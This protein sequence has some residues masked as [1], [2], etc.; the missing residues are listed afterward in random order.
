M[1]KALI[2][3]LAVALCAGLVAKGGQPEGTGADRQPETI[4]PAE[5]NTVIPVVHETP[6]HVYNSLG[7][8]D[9]LF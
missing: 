9:G 2:L 1:K 4:L 5:E 3:I 7:V 6:V 8:K